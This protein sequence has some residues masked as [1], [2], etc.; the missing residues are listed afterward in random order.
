MKRLRIINL[1][2]FLSISTIA[3]IALAEQTSLYLPDEQLTPGAAFT[4]AARQEICLPGY[5]K[6]VRAVPPKVKQQVYREY[7]IRQHKPGEYEVDH[8]VPLE[9]GGSNEISNLWPEPYHGPNNAHNKDKLEDYSAS[10]G[11]CG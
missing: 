9:L 5:A 6:R 8:L 1:F 10:T 11:M 3:S 2:F 7:G 4:D